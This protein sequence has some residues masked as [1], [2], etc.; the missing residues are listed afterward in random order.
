[1]NMTTL[2]RQVQN[3]TDTYEKEDWLRWESGDIILKKRWL[4]TIVNKLKL[5]KSEFSHLTEF[6]V[7]YGMIDITDDSILKIGKKFAICRKDEY[8]YVQIPYQ[9]DIGTE[10][11]YYIIKVLDKH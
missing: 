2:S 8:T 4:D 6:L 10:Y 3:K 5:T 7:N 1:M 11:V 9:N